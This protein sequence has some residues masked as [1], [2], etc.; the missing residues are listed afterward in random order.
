MRPTIADENVLRFCCALA[1]QCFNNEYVFAES[2][3][4]LD[5][6]ERQ[7]KLLH[8]RSCGKHRHSAATARRGGQLSSAVFAA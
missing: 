4:E 2:S 1:R 5:L 3:D 8:R 6:V 7:N